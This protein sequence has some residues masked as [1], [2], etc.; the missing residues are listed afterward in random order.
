MY[1]WFVFVSSDAADTAKIKV[2]HYKFQPELPVF[3]QKMPVRQ[4]TAAMMR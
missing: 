2:F 3:P 4:K 1:Q